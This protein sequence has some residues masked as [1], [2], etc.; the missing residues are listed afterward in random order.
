MKLRFSFTF[1]IL[2]PY[3]A[4][5][6]LFFI[7]FLSEFQQGLTLIAWLAAAG[8]FLSIL[9]GIFYKLWIKKPL[10]RIRKLVVQL[11]RGHIPEFKA[12]PS[13]DEVGDLELSLEKHV[14]N[15]RD[16]AA[17]TRSM[18]TGDFTGRYEKLSNEDELG[19]A[20]ISL[21]GS[22]MGSMKDSES[23]RREEENRTWT[24]QGLA[25]FS[26]LFREVEDNL[27]DLSRTLLKELV[28]YTEADVGALFITQDDEEGDGQFLE[29]CGSYAFDR[30]KFIHR[31]F[32]FGEGLTGRAAVEREPIY[33][34]D[35]PPGYM[36]IR[37]GLGE[38]VPSSILLVPVM[39]DNN[40]LGVIELASLGEIPSHQVDFVCQLAEAL[41]T[42]LA[43]VQANLRTKI[44]FEQTKK[45]AEELAS[46]ENVF[47]QNVQKLEKAQEKSASREAALLKEIE[48]LQKG[49]S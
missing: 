40:V 1:K 29:I 16:I 3:L 4:L 21:K 12:S 20:L 33:I 32:R 6:A 49:S 28:N 9:L 23:R 26:T 24:A 37:S 14:G 35:L 45:Q 46:Q 17:F 41:A 31:S 2:L 27:E 22:L 42:T 18:S 11:A 39:L 30:E 7:I 13:G 25:M 38:D 47:K 34:T 43:K 48:S 15:L 5:A 8:V 10:N 44:L 36:K 19:V